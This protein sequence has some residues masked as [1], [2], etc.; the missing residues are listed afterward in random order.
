MEPILF[1]DN[2]NKPIFIFILFIIY[3][4][5]L[6]LEKVREETFLAIIRL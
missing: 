1:I 6:F 4:L 2:I 3:F 5:L